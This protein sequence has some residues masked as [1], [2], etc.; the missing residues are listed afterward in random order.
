MSNKSKYSPKQ[1][2]IIGLIVMVVLS[3]VVIFASGYFENQGETTVTLKD[4][5]YKMEARDFD[6][7]GYKGMV[8]MEVAAGAITSVTWD[9][10]NEAGEYKSQLSMDGKYVMT[11]SNP[12]WHEQAEMLAKYVIEN[13]SVD[14]LTMDADGKTDAVASVSISIQG[15]VD[16]V[17]DCLAEASK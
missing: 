1:K 17:T 15:F 11:D 2:G 5:S 13:Q 3:V 10:V 9:L 6:G 14:G 8:S 12:M 7:S 4:G 16:L